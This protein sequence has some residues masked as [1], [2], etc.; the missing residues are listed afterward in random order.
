MKNK[1]L[2]Y[3]ALLGLSAGLV[4]N[5]S[6][7]TSNTE[8]NKKTGNAPQEKPKATDKD[9]PNKGNLG[10]HLMTEDELLSELTDDTAKLYEGLSPEGKKLARFVASQ[11]CN[12]SNECKGLNACQTDNNKCAGQGK[13][14]GTSKCAIS[15]KNLAVKIVAKKMAEKRSN[16]NH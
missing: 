9:D 16:L 4:A 2:K 6:A 5:A 15:D 11:R 12:G 3:L 10:Y 1:K 13:C 8:T 14:K 7:A